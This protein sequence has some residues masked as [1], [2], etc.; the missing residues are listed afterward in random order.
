VSPFRIVLF[1]LLLASPAFAQVCGDSTLDAGEGCDDGDVLP[2]DGCDASCN[3]ETGFLCTDPLLFDGTWTTEQ[4][5][6][7]PAW[8]IGNSG[9]T[10]TKGN[11]NLASLFLSP[12]SLSDG[13][14]R[15]LVEAIG[16]DDD[17]IGLGLGI[18][19]GDASDSSASYL[20][21]DWKRRNQTAYAAFG[22]EGMAVSQVDGLPSQAEF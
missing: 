3:V 20:L 7:G 16:G 2:G 9:A 19:P 18:E 15:V 1:A 12:F 8:T 22:A 21:L 14:F 17:F 10:V 5:G 6:S 11:A 13:P 4:Y